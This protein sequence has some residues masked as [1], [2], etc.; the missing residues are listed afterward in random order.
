MLVTVIFEAVMLR[1]MLTLAPDQVKTCT[2][3]TFASLSR[4][5]VAHSLSVI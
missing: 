1:L 3:E 4:I 5:I 2:H